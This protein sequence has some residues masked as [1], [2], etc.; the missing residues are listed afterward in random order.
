MSDKLIKRIRTQEGDLQIDYS[1]IGNPPEIDTSLTKAGVAADAAAVKNKLDDIY[2][3]ISRINGTDALADITI[4]G[5]PIK[6][7]PTLS[8][9]DVGAAETNHNHDATDITSGEIGIDRIPTLTIAKGGTGSENGKDG[10]KNLLASGPMILSS[11]NQYG[12]PAQFQALKE[13][14]RA[15]EGQVFFVKVSN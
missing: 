5:K 11:G 7:N 13:S 2:S 6:N 12:T 9:S 15:E 1:A 8:A 3:Q 10:L 4:N 14:G